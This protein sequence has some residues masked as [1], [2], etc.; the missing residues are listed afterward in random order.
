MGPDE[1]QVTFTDSSKMNLGQWIWMNGE[2][3][4]VSTPTRKRAQRPKHLQSESLQDRTMYVGDHQEACSSIRVL[5][6]CVALMYG[7][8]AYQSQ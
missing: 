5:S 7:H 8:S 6:K 2:I 4:I 1:G 3:V